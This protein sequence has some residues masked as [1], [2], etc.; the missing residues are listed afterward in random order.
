VFESGND[1]AP[2]LHP[3]ET[4]DTYLLATCRPRAFQSSI[5]PSLRA[6]EIGIRMALGAGHHE[7]LR[8]VLRE[9]AV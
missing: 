6:R 4:I 3:S 5:R 7:V 1:A 9:I 2:T 8:L